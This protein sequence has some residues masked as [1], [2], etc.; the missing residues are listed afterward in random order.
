VKTSG[1]E[2]WRL[3]AF[4]LLELLIVLVIIGILGTMLIPVYASMRARGQRVRC[5]ANLHNLYLAA[6]VYLQRN[7]SWPQIS[8]DTGD[9]DFANA[10]INA[11][12][13]FGRPARRGSAPPSR[14][15]CKIPI[16]SRRRTP[17][18]IISR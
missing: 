5:I 8:H 16:T 7:G 3:G 15:S 12:S 2:G 14:K 6:D 9:A 17:G 4:T 10:L 18:S 1:C 13:P 11:L